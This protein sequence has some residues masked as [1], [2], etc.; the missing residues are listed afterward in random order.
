MLSVAA[1]E[2]LGVVRPF[3]LERWYERAA[4]G[5][6]GFLGVSSCHSLA[7]GLLDEIQKAARSGAYEAIEIVR[8]QL[9][10]LNHVGGETLRHGARRLLINAPQIHA[11]CVTAEDLIRAATQRGFVDDTIPEPPIK[12]LPRAIGARKNVVNVDTLG[13]ISGELDWLT[14][15]PIPTSFPHQETHDPLVGSTLA[16]L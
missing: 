10:L 15:D 7:R 1:S 8:A 12:S 13:K 11:R 3:Y 14:V 9:A 4:E 2:A 16:R 5:R 6:N